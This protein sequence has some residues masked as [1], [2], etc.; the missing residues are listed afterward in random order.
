M[1]QLTIAR[2]SLQRLSR[3]IAAMS[4]LTVAATQVEAQDLTVRIGHF[5]NITHV[6]V[7]VAR[8]LERQGQGWFDARL[9]PGVKVA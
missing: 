6:Q 1:M 2:S 5:P 3:V 8:N 9:G 4:L 7:L